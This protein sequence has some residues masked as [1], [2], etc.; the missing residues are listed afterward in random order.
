MWREKG[1]RGHALEGVLG[2]FTF[3]FCLPDAREWTASSLHASLPS[4]KCMP[5]VIPHPCG[6]PDEVVFILLKCILHMINPRHRTPGYQSVGLGFEPSVS[7]P[8]CSLAIMKL[9]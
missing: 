1:H 8:G 6:D 7:N 9:L 2:I 4:V 3:S 5:M